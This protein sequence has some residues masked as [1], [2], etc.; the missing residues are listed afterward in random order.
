MLMQEFATHP[1]IVISNSY[2][3]EVKLAS[4]YAAAWS[5]LSASS[6]LPGEMEMEF[7][8]HASKDFLIGRN[9]WNRSDLL[10]RTGGDNAAR[11]IHESFPN[12]LGDLFR[13]I[14]EDYYSIVSIANQVPARL[15][16]EKSPI[17]E[18]VRQACRALFGAV[19]E[20]VLVRD[21]RDYLCSAKS[22]WKT[23]PDEMMT[24]MAAEHPILMDI[25]RAHPQDVLF[26]RYEDLVLDGSAERQR[27][28]DFLGCDASF[29]PRAI[30]ADTVPDSH[31]TSRSA[32]AS[33]GRFR[34]DLDAETIRVCEDIYRPFMEMFDYK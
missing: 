12:R 2:P 4:Y 5:V 7:A 34:D 23:R 11:L 14:V 30:A 29:K 22:F 6:Y 32:S 27:I 3:F 15:F 17:N 28:Y 24:A 26:I 20:I 19:K 31:R 8:T 21:P 25:F 16:A 18:P 9:P 13:S 10:T 1:E 33:V